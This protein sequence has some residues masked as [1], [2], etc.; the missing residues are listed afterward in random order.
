MGKT[1]EQIKAE[2]KALT[3][4]IKPLRKTARTIQELEEL[5]HLLKLREFKKGI[6]RT[7]KELPDGQMTDDE[8]EDR[9]EWEKRTDMQYGCRNPYL[10]LG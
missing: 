3:V 6:L 10:G 8:L 5:I 9:H 7:N 2:I 1:E 4:K